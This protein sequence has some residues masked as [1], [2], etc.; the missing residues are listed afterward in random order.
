MGEWQGSIVD[1]HVGWEK[2]LWSF[3]ENIISHKGPESS[4]IFEG[5]Y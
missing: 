2:L 4:P 5:L 3:L 1:K